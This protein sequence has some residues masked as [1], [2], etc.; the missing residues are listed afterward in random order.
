MA[1]YL[2]CEISLDTRTIKTGSSVYTVQLNDNVDGIRFLLPVGISEYITLENPV[3]TLLYLAP[4][5][6]QG[7]T[8]TLSLGENDGTFYFI[9]WTFETEFTQY[10][11]VGTFS[12]CIESFENAG[13]TSATGHWNSQPAK[14]TVYPTMDH[15]DLVPSSDTEVTPAYIVAIENAVSAYMDD[16]PSNGIWTE[17]AVAKLISIL[18]EGVY[19]TDTSSDITALNTLL[20]GDVVHCTGITLSASTLSVNEGSTGTLTATVTPSTCTETVTWSSSDTSVA[21]VADGTV[22]AVSAGNAT[23]TATCGNYSAT[24][25]VTIVE[26]V[27]HSITYSLTNVTST[28]NTATVEDSTY[29]STT[30]TADSGYDMASV[31]VTMGGTDVTSDVYSSSTGDILITSVTGDVVIT[32]VAEAPTTLEYYAF[33]NTS[34]NY[35]YS[36]EG[37]TSIGTKYNISKIYAK[38]NT[39]TDAT[40]TVTL[41][42][43]TDSDVSWEGYAGAMLSDGS[44]D[45]HTKTYLYNAVSMT[46]SSRTISAGNSLTATVTVP[47]GMRAA[48]VGSSTYTDLDITFTASGYTEDTLDGYTEIT[49]GSGYSYHTLNV[50][51]GSDT[52]STLLGTTSGRTWITQDTSFTGGTQYKIR[53]HSESTSIESGTAVG[54]VTAVADTDAFNGIYTPFRNA[55]YIDYEATV[56]AISDYIF[57]ALYN[58]GFSIYVK[59]VS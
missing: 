24:C 45:S 3:V 50:Y 14:I 5:T 6:S 12:I 40:V 8:L 49:Q 51:E 53:L 28:S 39:T 54:F 38:Y 46:N 56:T 2:D 20:G 23:I 21:T 59:E 44:Y 7:R 30:L 43:N 35:I 57:I 33:G 25:A 42:N 55:A 41:T 34:N 19:G 47:A 37:T 27:R 26:T 10:S 31:T 4:G 48:F 52:S 13:D 1:E 11:G 9:F 22:T 15:D 58:R 18:R 29:Y 17:E 16:N 32:A 36:D